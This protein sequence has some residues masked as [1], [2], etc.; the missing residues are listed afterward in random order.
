MIVNDIL[1][2]IKVN[3]ENPLPVFTSF[4]D[5]NLWIRQRCMKVLIV[6]QKNGKDLSRKAVKIFTFLRHEIK[7]LFHAYRKS[8][9]ESA[10]TRVPLACCHVFDEKPS[11]ILSF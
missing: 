9:K 4:L 1:K 5:E 6:H 11:N 8:L 10:A 7:D 3:D 2:D